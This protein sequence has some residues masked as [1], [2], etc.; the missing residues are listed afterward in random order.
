MPCSRIKL[1]ADKSEGCYECNEDSLDICK[2]C[3][4]SGGRCLDDQHKPYLRV[5][6]AGMMSFVEYTPQI[7]DMS[8]IEI[9]RRLQQKRRLIRRQE[10]E[11]QKASTGQTTIMDNLRGYIQH[12]VGMAVAAVILWMVISVE[13]GM[14]NS[15]VSGDYRYELCNRYSGP[16]N[17][18]WN[19]SFEWFCYVES[20]CNNWDFYFVSGF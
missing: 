1:T 10:R 17:L 14:Q 6:V 18:I 3:W 8:Y 7:A 4:D 19:V 5:M 2:E 13:K 20:A 12:G 15:W 16:P 11:Q 9:S